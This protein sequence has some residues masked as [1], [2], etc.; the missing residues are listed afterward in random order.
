M[1]NVK[2]FTIEGRIRG[3]KMSADSACKTAREGCGGGIKALTHLL[4]GNLAL[5]I[6]HLIEFCIAFGGKII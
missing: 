6:L 3:D 4:D 5:A 2:K 1:K